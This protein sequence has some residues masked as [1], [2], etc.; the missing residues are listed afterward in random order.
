MT[1]NRVNQK[2]E[3]SERKNS[4]GHLSAW[5]F[6]AQQRIYMFLAMYLFTLSGA[7]ADSNFS[8]VEVSRQRINSPYYTHGEPGPRVNLPYFTA[9]EILLWDGAPVHISATGDCD[10]RPL[11]RKNNLPVYPRTAWLASPRVDSRA[12]WVGNS[13]HESLIGLDKTGHVRWARSLPC[14]NT[15]PT[16]LIGAN[17]DGLVLSNLEVWSSSTGEIILPPSPTSRSSNSGLYRPHHRD[18]ILFDTESTL[19]SSQGGLW[20]FDPASRHTEL[21]QQAERRW[22]FGKVL[23]ED[24]AQDPGENYLYLAKR[25]EMRGPGWVAF[26]VFDPIRRITLFK[27]K[28]GRGKLCSNVR[29]TAG[30]NGHVAFSFHDGESFILIH[31][32]IDKR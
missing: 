17:R 26:E 12:C 4:A 31:Y 20:R 6:S 27:Q 3:I 24:I 19:Y 29:V 1:T 14:I 15:L 9:E 23:V 2:T 22:G 13:S 32:R 25:L 10:T 7:L 5:F 8:V 30:P 11:P 16:T 28:H 21:L 18:I